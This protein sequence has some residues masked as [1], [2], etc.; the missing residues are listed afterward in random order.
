MIMG[1]CQSTGAELGVPLAADRDTSLQLR[2][3][4]RYAPII[5]QNQKYKKI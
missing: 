5:L 4:A 1:V 3:H 2:Y